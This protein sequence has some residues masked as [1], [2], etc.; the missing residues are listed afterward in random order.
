MATSSRVTDLFIRLRSKNDGA[1]LAPPD[2]KARI[3]A[4]AVEKGTNANAVAVEILAR[5]FNVNADDW[6]QDG[7]RTRPG[8]PSEDE[9]VIVIGMPAK[10]RLALDRAAAARKNRDGLGKWSAQDE[11]RVALA[12]HYGLD[13][14]DA[15]V[16]TRRRRTADEV[17]A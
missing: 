13:V 8:K 15:P 6:G 14:P 10:L 7:R 3:V 5:T 4:D 2:L 12:A 17:A 16:R 11:A 9:Y 1:P